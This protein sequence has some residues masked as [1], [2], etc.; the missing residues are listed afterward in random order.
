MG[1]PT[2]STGPCSMSQT[3][4]L[5]EGRWCM[6]LYDDIIWYHDI[7][8]ISL[9]FMKIIDWD[10]WWFFRIHED[11]WLKNRDVM[12]HRIHGAAIY[13]KHGSHQSSP[14]MLAYIYQ[15]YGSVMGDEI[16]WGFME[17]VVVPGRRWSRSSMNVPIGPSASEAT[18]R[19]RGAV[20]FGYQAIH[21]ISWKFMEH[22]DNIWSYMIIYDNIW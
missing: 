18:W 10:I 7:M 22:R 20:G 19:A 13:G 12:T 9:G 15:H 4:S 3:V 1:K 17:I 14:F 11:Y 6:M 8:M 21:Q 5:P 2:I 16:H